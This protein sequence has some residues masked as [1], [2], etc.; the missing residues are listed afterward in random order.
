MTTI[1]IIRRPHPCTGKAASDGE[2]VLVKD[3]LARLRT[4]Q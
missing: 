3:A 1:E 4:R 2:E